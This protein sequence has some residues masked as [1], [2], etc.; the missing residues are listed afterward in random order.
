M[1]DRG[2][3]R[4]ARGTLVPGARRRAGC[5]SFTGCRSPAFGVLAGATHAVGPAQ[6]GGPVAGGIPATAPLSIVGR[7]ARAPRVLAAEGHDEPGD[8]SAEARAAARDGFARGGSCRC[9]PGRGGRPDAAATPTEPHRRT[10]AGGPRGRA[11][12]LPG[13]PRSNGDRTHLEDARE[14]REESSQA[15]PGDAARAYA[16][17]SR[18]WW[19]AASPT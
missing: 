5:V 11:V 12:A 1:C 14:H 19:A 18:A 3:W 2:Q 6:G 15:I 8:R 9:R 13:G 7:V 4:R 16:G 17:R 10:A